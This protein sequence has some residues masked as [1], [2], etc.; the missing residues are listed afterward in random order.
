LRVSSTSV[1]GGSN[2]SLVAVVLFIVVITVV[3]HFLRGFDEAPVG[4]SV[5][6]MWKFRVAALEMQ[7]LLWSVLG[8]FIGWL[9]NRSLT[10]QRLQS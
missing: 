5:T 9:A 6:L 1:G 7:M 4:F 10:A 3:S 8:F 2:A